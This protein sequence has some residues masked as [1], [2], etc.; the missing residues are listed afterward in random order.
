MTWTCILPIHPKGMLLTRY[1]WDQTHRLSNS[2]LRLQW[3]F[4][5]SVFPPECSMYFVGHLAWTHSPVGSSWTNR[6][7]N[8]NF[9]LAGIIG[10]VKWLQVYINVNH[11]FI[12][13]APT[14]VTSLGDIKTERTF[15]LLPK[16]FQFSW[17][18][19]CEE[20]LRNPKREVNERGLLE[21]FRE[22]FLE[23]AVP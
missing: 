12:S 6:W 18:D 20:I 4:Y 2:K 5:C 10:V 16:R 8:S 13:W 15:L 21:D 9:A 19:K 23:E 22:G 14:M 1:E 11:L 3:S 17:T 7:M